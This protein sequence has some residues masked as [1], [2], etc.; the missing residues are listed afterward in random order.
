[1]IRRAWPVLLA[2]ALS[3]ACFASKGMRPLAMAP[4]RPK[5]EAITVKLALRYLMASSGFWN[6]AW[7]GAASVAAAMARER[8]QLDFCDPRAQ[9]PGGAV[10]D[11][12]FEVLVYTWTARLKSFDHQLDEMETQYSAA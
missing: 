11:R 10:I 5:C 3:A 1:M 12:D 8:Y 2:A 4:M 7:A 6:C 9:L